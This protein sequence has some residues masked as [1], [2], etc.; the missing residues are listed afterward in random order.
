MKKLLSLFLAILMIV[1]SIPTDIVNTGV[2]ALV[3][4]PI[5]WG[6]LTS[7]AGNGKF[8]KGDGTKENPYMIQN[9][10]QLYKMVYSFGT[11]ES[12]NQNGTPAYYKLECDIY[13]NDISNYDNWGKDGFDMSSLNN[14][15]QY[16]DSFCHRAFFGNFDGDGY[17]I[18][19]LYAQG[20]RVSAFF[21]NV[22]HG[23][24]V[25]NVN[26]RNSYILNTSGENASDNEDAGET[27]GE[28][29][30]Y[31]GAFGSAGV[32]FSNA[33]NAG[34]SDYNTVDFT[35]NNCSVVDAYVEAKYFTSAFVGAAN[36]CQPYIA[37]CMTANVTLNSTSET[38]GV[39]GGILNMP[40]GSTNPSSVIENV[41]CVGWPIYGVGRDEMWSGKK[42]PSVSHTYTFNNVYSTVSNKYTFNHSS[43]GSVSFTDSEVTVVDASKIIGSNAE[44][45]L[46]GFDW[47]Y[48]WRTVDGD[49]PLP[50][51][52]Y[53]QPTGAQYYQNGGPKYATD[54]WNGSASAHF[55]AGDGSIEDPYLIANCEEFYRMATMPED[56]KYY[57]IADGVTDLYFNDIE[58]KSYSSLMSSFSS[59]WF[60][61][62][63]S[64]SIGDNVQFN[65]SFDG[66]GVI[67]HGIRSSVTSCTGI[68]ANVGNATI[69]NFKVRYSYFK[70]SGSSGNGAAAIVGNIKDNST[71]NLRNI[72]IV[73][74]DVY[75]KTNAAGFVAYAGAKSNLYIENCIVS[76]GKIPSGGSPSYSAAFLANGTNCSATIKNSIAVGVYPASKASVSYSAK[77]S[78]VYTTATAPTTDVGDATQN[79]SIVSQGDLQGENAKI[80][81]KEFD[82]NYA[83]SLTEGYPSPKNQQ[84]N[85]GVEGESWSG[86]IAMSFAGGNGTKSSPYQI[87]TPEMLARMLIYGNVGE[88]YKLTADVYI[89]DISVS[90]WKNT[91]LEWF[92]SEDV[93][94]FEGSFDGNGYT[95]HGLYCNATAQNEYAALIPVIGTNAQIKKVIIDNSYYT[96]VEGSYLG[97]I[98]GVLEDN[99]AVVSNIYACIIKDNV[100]FSGSADFGGM[101]A[102]VGFSRV[103]VE[104]CLF[105]G[106]FDTTGEANGIC[107]NVVGKI[108]IKECISL[109]AIPFNNDVNVSASNIYTNYETNKNGVIVL[110]IDKMK[111]VSA[112]NNMTA[113]DFSSLWRL[114]ST[115]TP[116][117]TGNTK[118]YKGVKGAVW[119][120]KIASSFASG[121][122]S[123]NS[124]YI[125]ET[126]E[127][128]ALL[129][130]KASDYS[131]KYFRL[132]CDIYLNDITGELW[133]NKC[134][135]TNWILSSEATAFDCYLDGNGYAVFGMYYDYKNT[136]KNAYMGL[137][138]RLAGSSEIKNLGVSQAYVNAR[139]DNSGIYAGGIFGMGS[140]IYDFYGNN[141]N[142]L[143]TTGD[144]FLIPGQT[145]PTKL[146]SI[147]NCFVD[148][149][150]YINAPN[151]GGIGCAGGAA[152]V[153]RDCYVTAS[154]I[155]KSDTTE[156]ALLGPNWANC[157]RVYNSF[158]FP[159][160]DNKVIGGNQQW[161]SGEAT[162]CTY[163]ENVYYYGNK[164]IYGTTQIKRPQWRIGELAKD[165][166]SG[167][168]WENVWRVEEDGTPVLRVFDKADRS[169]AV[170]SDKYYEIP[171][172]TVSFETNVE[173]LVIEPLVG[174]AYEKIDLPTPTRQGYKFV[175]WHGYE[176]LT[177]VY[178]YEH[179]LARD[180]TLYAEWQ[181]VSIA[182]DFEKY[183]YTM[184]DCD[185]AVWRYNEPQN[186]VEYNKNF[187]HSG[188]KSIQLMNSGSEIVTLLVNYRKTLTAGQR[189]TISLWTASANNNIQ[190]QLALSHKVYPDYM[191][192][193]KLIEPITAQA[194]TVDKWTKYEY[195]FEAQTP[196]IAIKVLDGDGLYFDD[197]VVELEGELVSQTETSKDVIEAEF[198]GS[199]F[200]GAVLNDGVGEVGEFA[201]AYN[202]FMTDIFIADSVTQIKEYAFYSCKRLTDIWY[203]GSEEDFKTLVI[204]KNNDE[205]EDAVWHFDSCGIGQTHVYDNDVDAD[206]NVCGKSRY[207]FVVGDAN[208]DGNIN[209]RDYAMILQYINGWEVQINQKG[210]D[211][212][213]DGNINGRDYAML[214]Q[215]INGWDIKFN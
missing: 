185:T 18:Y 209:G 92:T 156:G 63:N 47:A 115:D 23:A 16:Q 140:G 149:T 131:K 70:T 159:Q 39:E 21:P 76:G 12:T 113:L 78:G 121:T 102:E 106:S 54:M 215:Y 148:H 141:T 37:N 195:T 71:V 91:A 87:N 205:L 100:T 77:Y 13:L 173:V 107:V 1:L 103:V 67:I 35:I 66:N 69:K 112:R 50:M 180:I 199:T 84:T 126:G 202:K 186:S 51:R 128:L 181:E 108:E 142:Y 97:G 60:F 164:R 134:G 182:Q 33:M 30:W 32:I 146:P 167:L 165:N 187:V 124:P 139:G 179:F 11:L 120:G 194:T 83:W 191:A 49:Y 7:A 86:Q 178:E 176:D 198:Y 81:C 161:V 15:A 122:G 88:Y 160:T 157:S 65:G 14:W 214:L 55:A 24:V 36:S 168:D 42:Q 171:R 208:G 153:I 85:N 10:D 138:P 93:S 145:T 210:A 114:S 34:D 143:E 110:T 117:P 5:I 17:T 127:Q 207:D 152:I 212:N 89:N 25:K 4:E 52:E 174:L 9:G 22:S 44:S 53:V 154:L 82:W 118:A 101:I 75:S 26:F 211:V 151:I 133:Q 119:T 177:C 74:C 19:G 162:I 190:P 135:A 40:Y 129:I 57:K 62:G 137:I 155:G 184:W 41:L 175:A 111:G 125:I 45:V 73:D 147:V 166:M 64:Y 90:N 192:A 68:F 123:Q 144:E 99:A 189:Y 109:N 183:P 79:V 104:N 150:C 59:S 61:S 201:F 170:F 46:T 2:S 58:G 105:K 188:E 95:I 28:K 6:G 94:A 116:S 80:T 163:T 20:Y 48:T 203:A 8:T 132:A 193:E 27:T 130:T 200:D 206:C 31:A 96:G 136:P 43:Y 196:W 3:N 38:Q 172:V 72:E 204:D 169:A 197:I 158:A 29:V 56:D 98:V 213:G